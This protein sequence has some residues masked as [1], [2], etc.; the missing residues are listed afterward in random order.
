MSSDCTHRGKR[1]CGDVAQ[2]ADIAGYEI[3][4]VGKTTV[5]LTA[6]RCVEMVKAHHGLSN[7]QLVRGLGTAP[8]AIQKIAMCAGS[9]GS[10][11]DGTKA[12]L[13]LTGEMSHHEQLAWQ[14]SGTSIILTGHTEC[15]RPY[16]SVL[17]SKLTAAGVDCAVSTMDKSPLEW[18]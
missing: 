13:I 8:S 16:M 11:V 3:G 5:P 4:R 17:A 10:V 9:G 1:G 15:E 12:D 18:H 2:P 14:Y 7:V 6:E